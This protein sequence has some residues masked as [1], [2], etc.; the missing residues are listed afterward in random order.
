MCVGILV[1]SLAATVCLSMIAYYSAVPGKV[2]PALAAFGGGAVLMLMA[3][4]QLDRLAAARR[5]NGE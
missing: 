2:Y 1:T 4:A 3:G 5:R